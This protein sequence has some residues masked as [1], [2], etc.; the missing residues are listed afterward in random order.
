MRGESPTLTHAR[1][2]RERR[3]SSAGMAVAAEISLYDI[4]S[5]VLNSSR[6]HICGARVKG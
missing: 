5:S 4:E 1:D 6:M 3:R 2:C